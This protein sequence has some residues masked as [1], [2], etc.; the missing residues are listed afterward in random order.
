[1]LVLALLAFAAAAASDQGDALR[2]CRE[3]NYPAVVSDVA[4]A[5]FGVQSPSAADQ[6]LVQR[7]AQMS[8]DTSASV[9]CLFHWKLL[10][11]SHVFVLDNSKPAC[12][13]LC[14]NVASSCD[15]VAPNYCS[16][17]GAE[18]TDYGILTG[19][20][21][22]DNVGV[23]PALPPAVRAGASRSSLSQILVL[24]VAIG[25]WTHSPNRPFSIALL[26]LAVAF[27]LGK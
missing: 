20:C 7:Y 4:A 13:S 12:A 9:T 17:A 16:A 5:E 3:L 11:C 14:Q 8:A 18:C 25:F 22:A 15:A 27:V 10:L 1:M 21:A 19:L 23:A 6:Q 24:A 2:L 26:V